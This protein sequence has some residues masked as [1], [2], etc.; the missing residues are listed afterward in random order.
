MVKDTRAPDGAG[1][2]LAVNRPQPITVK[3]DCGRRPMEVTQGRSRC[4]GTVRSAWRIDDEW[5]REE[6]VSR[7]YYSVLLETGVVLTIFRD[8][9][10]D[11]W[12]KQRYG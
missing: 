5:W 6:P 9:I 4:K 12:Y 10:T 8:L 2:I 7:L 3:T 11:K 1:R